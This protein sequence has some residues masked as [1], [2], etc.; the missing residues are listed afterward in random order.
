VCIQVRK[1]H[2]LIHAQPFPTHDVVTAVGYQ[3]V[4]VMYMGKRGALT[5]DLNLLNDVIEQNGGGA[6]PLK[7]E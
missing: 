1:S 6:E 2:H 5:V 4:N 3:F 7:P